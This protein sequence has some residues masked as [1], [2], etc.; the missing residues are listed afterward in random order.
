MELRQYLSIARKW[1]WLILLSTV[2][3]A[4]AG[5]LFSQ[6]QS[7]VYQATS[8]LVVGRSIQ[9]TELTSADIWTSEQL[10]RTYADMAGFQPVLQGVVEAI[11]LDDSW[12]GLGDR[13][14]VSPRRDTQL[15]DITVEA[16]PPEEARVTADELARQLIRLS[17]SALQDQQRSASQQFARLRLESLQ[18]KIVAGQARLDELETAMEEP[19]SAQQVQEI[20]DEI[21]TLEGLVADW[22]SNYTLLYSLLES[23]QSPN[24]LAVVQPAQAGSSPIRPNVRQDTLLAAVVGLLLALGVIFLIEYLD[25]TLKSAADLDQYL[26]LT[27]LGAVGQIKGKSHDK[28][29]AYK[30]P[31]SP[32]AEAYRII[33]SNIQFMAVDRPLKAIMVTS[34]T[35]SEGKSLTVANLGVVMAHAGLKTIIVDSDLRRPAQHLIFGLSNRQGLTNL[36]RSPGGAVNGYLEETE[37][38]NLQVLTCGEVPPNPSELLGS[39]RMG[40]LMTRLEDVADVVLFDSP[41]VLAVADATVLSKR[42]DGL[43]LVTEAGQTRRGA[44]QQAVVNLRQAG[45]RMLGAVLNGVSHKGGGYYYYYS[46]YYHS[47]GKDGSGRQRGRSGKDAGGKRLAFLK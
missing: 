12:Q 40:Q 28:L 42:V 18:A 2:L 24:Y 20:Q 32:Q 27:T 22:E 21:N 6:R 45:A 11:S 4:G 3:G 17:P 14:K 7:P 46:S 43:V 38:E 41:P 29:V 19:L 44:A 5:F 30:E 15:R 34:P 37:I 47:P 33:R 8:V 13:V 39:Q 31:H 25:D 16:S 36:L 26:G 1:W 35:S 9:S 10:A 23:E